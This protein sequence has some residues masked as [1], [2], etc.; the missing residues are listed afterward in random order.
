VKLILRFPDGSAFEASAICGI[1]WD[2]KRGAD[3][4]ACI[5]VYARR[6]DLLSLGFGNHE[7]P[8]EQ[9]HYCPM[10]SDDAARKACEEL[11]AAWM[12]KVFTPA[13]AAT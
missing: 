9:I 13:P 8:V 6:R 12:G 5:R 4:K 10:D 7:A 11:T 3:G 1:T 2:Q